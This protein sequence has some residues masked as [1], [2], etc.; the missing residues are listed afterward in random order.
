MCVAYLTTT[1]LTPQ[2]TAIVS[3]RRSV[4][5]NDW[6]AVDSPT[7]ARDATDSVIAES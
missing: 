6:G 5:P 4:N 1:K 2:I 7:A 3:R